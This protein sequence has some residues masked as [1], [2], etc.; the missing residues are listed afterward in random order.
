MQQVKR[1]LFL[2]MFMHAIN[3]LNAQKLSVTF[4]QSHQ[5]IDVLIGDK[6]FTSF[7]YPDTLE[8]PVLYPVH[9]ANGTL[10]TRGF[11][12]DPRPGDPTDHPHHI[13][14]WFNYEN[15]NGL[16]F[17]NN[18]YAIPAERKSKY[19][20]IK[21]AKILSVKEGKKGE[22]SYHARWTN[23]QDETQLEETTTLLFS[24]DDHIRIIDRVTTL[25][26]AREVLMK[27]VKDGLIGF[28]MAHELQ[29]PANTDK[30]F[31]DDKGIVT[32]VKG[33]PDNIANGN[34]LTS[35]GKMG[36]SAWSTRARWCKA[37]AKMGSDSV[38]VTIIDHP[39]NT[40][41]PTYWHARGYGLFAANPLGATVFSNGKH[42]TNLHLNKGESVVFRYRVVVQNGKQTLTVKELDKLADEFAK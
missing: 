31:K 11:P 22:L 42:T 21:T 34:Y 35:E 10:V 29:I 33:A 19:G 12:I 23:Q 30:T 18:S 39:S 36:D 5:R 1:V 17:W 37:F 8:K 15:V 13:G 4:K 28:R 7:L 6:P 2:L 32:V 25:T 26:A 38:S 9:A 20:W 16:D 24:G 14:I 3:H 40:N 27:D 41:Y